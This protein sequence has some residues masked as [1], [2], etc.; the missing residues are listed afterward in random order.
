MSSNPSVKKLASL[1]QNL[2]QQQ[3]QIDPENIQSI[4][5]PIYFSTTSSRTTEYI[6]KKKQQLNLSQRQIQRLITSKALET[7]SNKQEDKTFQDGLYPSV[8][9]SSTPNLKIV[10]SQRFPQNFPSYDQGAPGNRQSD[11]YR[12]RNTQTME[13]YQN[14]D[15]GFRNMKPRVPFPVIGGVSGE[16][17][18]KHFDSMEPG[19]KKR[20][21][22]DYVS[23]INEEPSTSS[24]SGGF[25]E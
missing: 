25:Y 3:S 21:I 12:P 20:R 15:N 2:H 22:E 11:L 8:L 1:I 24:S 5:F 23:F 16:I 18:K 9:T 4:A 19:R 17:Y 10:P 14:Y 7:I 13:L 6:N